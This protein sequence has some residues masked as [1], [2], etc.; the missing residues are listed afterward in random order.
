[1]KRANGVVRSSASDMASSVSRLK[2]EFQA[3]LPA[4]SAAALV[5][6]G[7]AAFAEADHINDLSQRVGILGSTLSA[8]NIP[9]RQSGSSLDEFASTIVRMNNSIG[10]AAKG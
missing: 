2:A 9:L 3:L 8:L 4:I 1:M 7:R 6:F 10:E 5:Q